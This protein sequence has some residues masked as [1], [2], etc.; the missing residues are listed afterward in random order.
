[1]TTTRVTEESRR[2][3]HD[4]SHGQSA[5]GTRP[6]QSG[7]SLSSTQ[8]HPSGPPPLE[9]LKARQHKPPRQAPQLLPPNEMVMKTKTNGWVNPK[10]IW[11]E[12]LVCTPLPEGIKYT[13]MKTAI[14]PIINPLQY[15]EVTSYANLWASL[16]RGITIPEMFICIFQVI[17]CL[18]DHSYYHN[19]APGYV[20]FQHIAAANTH[21]LD[22]DAL[23][24]LLVTLAVFR[25]QVTNLPQ[26]WEEI[27][28][29]QSGNSDN[30]WTQACR[31][32]CCGDKSL[33]KT[34]LFRPKGQY[35]EHQ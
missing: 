20:V 22:Q 27:L 33:S 8:H 13:A 10:S 26:I 7:P 28:S 9:T 19:M 17:G 29:H 34:L 25:R 35:A 23:H 31:F 18:I 11:P 32:A 1:M 12:R 14:I 3:Y 21:H 5:S 15:P 24:S 6:S 30:D 4:E 2:T 16:T